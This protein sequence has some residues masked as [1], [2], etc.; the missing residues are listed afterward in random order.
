MCYVNLGLMHG[1]C[2]PLITGGVVQVIT[3]PYCSLTDGFF[4]L[5]AA[6]AWKLTI[7]L[8]GKCLPTGTKAWVA[9]EASQTGL[10]CLT[11]GLPSAEP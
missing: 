8:Y 1:V 6:N 4:F 9:S 2:Q 10:T 11:P 7:D 5:L 3:F